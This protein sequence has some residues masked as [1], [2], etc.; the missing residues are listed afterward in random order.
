MHWIHIFLKSELD[1]ISSEICPNQAL[2]ATIT[3]YCTLCLKRCCIDVDI[4]TA[5]FSYCNWVH[6]IHLLKLARHQRYHRGSLACNVHYSMKA[7]ILCI[8]WHIYRTTCFKSLLQIP[9]R[10]FFYFVGYE[11]CKNSYCYRYQLEEC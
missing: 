6:K 9:I 1:S 10:I 4:A 7:F 8:K 11:T 5:E 3:A 2:C